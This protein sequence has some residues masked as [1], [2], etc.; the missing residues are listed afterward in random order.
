MVLLSLRLVEGM[1][2]GTSLRLLY[3]LFRDAGYIFIRPTL[4][5]GESSNGE[6]RRN[7]SPIKKRLYSF[8]AY[9]VAKLY[10]DQFWEDKLK[11]EKKLFRYDN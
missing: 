3:S 1:R 5:F 8:A 4:L 7:I 2:H 9:F 6:K 10:A 11:K